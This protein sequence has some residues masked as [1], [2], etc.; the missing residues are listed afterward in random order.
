VE[1]LGIARSIKENRSKII[2]KKVLSHS[3]PYLLDKSLHVHPNTHSGGSCVNPQRNKC[4]SNAEHI[5]G[6]TFKNIFNFLLS[7]NEAIQQSHGMPLI[8]IGYRF[9][10][11]MGL[12]I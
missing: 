3:N 2:T 12:Q 5:L 7:K 1:S 4:S 6:F 11:S 9:K 8:S 10:I